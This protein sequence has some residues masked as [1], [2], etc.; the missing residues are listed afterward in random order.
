MLAYR[1]ISV[2]GSIPIGAGEMGVVAF[3]VFYSADWV[4]ITQYACSRCRGV[5]IVLQNEWLNV[6]F[7]VRELAHLGTSLQKFRA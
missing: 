3:H 5:W 1:Y 6:E 4:A 2:V 7:S